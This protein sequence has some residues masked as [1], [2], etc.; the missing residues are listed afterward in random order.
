[1]EP[2]VQYYQYDITFPPQMN[3]EIPRNFTLVTLLRKL[4]ALLEL[5]YLT[6]ADMER[7]LDDMKP[8]REEQ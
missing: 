1:M 6:A 3:I 4:I 2:L 8:I 7:A 5:K